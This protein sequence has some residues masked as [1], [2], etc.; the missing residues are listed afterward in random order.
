MTHPLQQSVW[1]K[2][3]LTQDSR[4]CFR[5]YQVIYFKVVLKTTPFR[6]SLEN[7]VPQ[8]LGFL[9]S[10]WFYMIG[11]LCVALTVLELTL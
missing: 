2:K 10:F 8:C 7:L 5:A 9:F 3:L 1:I 4:I 6:Y 11:F